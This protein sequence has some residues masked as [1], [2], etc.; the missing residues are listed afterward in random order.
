MTDGRTEVLCNSDDDDVNVYWNC[1]CDKIILFLRDISL[2]YSNIYICLI[3]K[4]IKI[5]IL[6]CRFFCW[7]MSTW[8]LL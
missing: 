1:I 6:K 5:M 8:N 2:K 7:F 3:F 4:N